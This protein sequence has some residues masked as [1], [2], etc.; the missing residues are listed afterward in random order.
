MVV[1]DVH[2]NDEVSQSINDD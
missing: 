2:F 1:Y